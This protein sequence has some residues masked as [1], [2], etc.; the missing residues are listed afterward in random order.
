M[1]ESVFFTDED[2]FEMW[3]DE[4]YL[5][6]EEEEFSALVDHEAGFDVDPYGV[7]SYYAEAMLAYYD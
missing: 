1:D 7:E 5:A 2:D 3:G 4:D 6:E